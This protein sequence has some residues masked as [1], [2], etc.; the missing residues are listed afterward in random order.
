MATMEN[1]E[2]PRGIPMEFRC[3]SCGND[4]F[5][6]AVKQRVVYATCDF[7]GRGFLSTTC[8]HCGKPLLKFLP[9]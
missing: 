8:E 2:Q 1:P 6:I 5:F 9:E 7:C 4:R 3:D